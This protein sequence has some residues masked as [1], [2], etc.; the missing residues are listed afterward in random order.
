MTD[1]EMGTLHVVSHD[2]ESIAEALGVDEDR[3]SEIL[4][5]VSTLWQN[6]NTVSETIERVCREYND[7]ECALA[8]MIVGIL[9][10]EARHERKMM[11][12]VEE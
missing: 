3:F 1:V 5:R 6:T 12:D 9:L 4:Q 7:S 8:L 11:E 10:E 2:S